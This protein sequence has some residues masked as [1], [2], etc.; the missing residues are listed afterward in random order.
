M[1]EGDGTGRKPRADEAWE[2]RPDEDGPLTDGDYASMLATL[3]PAARDGL[4]DFVMRT[5]SSDPFQVPGTGVAEPDTLPPPRPRPRTADDRA[6][7]AESAVHDAWTRSVPMLVHGSV[8]ADDVCRPMSLGVL[9]GFGGQA[10][11]VASA[12]DAAVY[13]AKTDG[14]KHLCARLLVDEAFARTQKETDTPGKLADC[15]RALMLDGNGVVLLAADAS[16]QPALAANAD[17]SYAL[18][19]LR[20]RLAAA[21]S[22][23]RAEGRGVEGPGGTTAEEA[24][25]ALSVPLPVDR[26]GAALGWLRGV[27]LR[28]K[29]TREDLAV[30][31]RFGTRAVLSAPPA[32]SG[33]ARLS[34]VRGLR[35]A[36]AARLREVCD[37]IRKPMDDAPGIVLEGPTG[38]GKTLL[39]R[40]VAAESG[41]H[42]VATSVTEWQGAGFLQDMLGSM[43][44]VFDEARRNAPSLIFLDELDSIGRRGTGDRNDQF[45]TLMINSFLEH[46]EGISGRG[47]VVVV[48]AT[49][50]LH[51][52]DPAILR[53]GR[54][55]EI[56]TVPV[57][58]RSGRAEILDYL[59]PASLTRRIDLLALADRVGECPSSQLKALAREAA[60]KAD[61]AEPGPEHVEMALADMGRRALAG[62]DP[63]RLRPLLSVG[64][65]SQALVAV[66]AFGDEVRIDAVS[67][68]PGLSDLGRV[69]M[70][71]ASGAFPTDTARDLVR[72]LHVQVAAGEGRRIAAGRLA[73]ARDLAALDMF[74]HLTA[75]EDA[76]AL[77]TARLLARSGLRGDVVPN[78][79]EAERAAVAYLD[80]ARR[81]ARRLLLRSFETVDAVSAVLKERGELPGDVVGRLLGGKRAEASAEPTLH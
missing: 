13:N 46:L 25:G 58:D 32:G 40:V 64:L 74:S 23:L 15:I 38:T 63:A 65:A 3:D 79:H 7:S 52:I 9:K 27:V 72:L 24:V 21:L 71:H 70:T 16:V 36:L 2:P 50:N 44:R 78:P 18:V 53:A 29:A 62:H 51:M 55:G 60:A 61:P 56:L 8:A 19:D 28:G 31:E 10:P 76:R 22:L 14:R 33:P 49:N 66:A 75:A 68:L 54:F 5:G 69:S 45:W 48:G 30:L 26:S 6:R 39:A 81:E 11:A 12:I 73:K 47:D 35:P 1:A 20:D 37:R 77:S 43:R 59:L 42:F 67:T 4:R 41:R 17:W 80:H 34:E 57:P